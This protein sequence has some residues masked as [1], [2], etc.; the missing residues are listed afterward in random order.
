MCFLWIDFGTVHK[1]T[2]YRIEQLPE[3]VSHAGLRLAPRRASLALQP[4]VQV[5]NRSASTQH[6]V[7][8]MFMHLEGFSPPKT[9]D[10]LLRPADTTKRLQNLSA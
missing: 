8:A 6:P 5:T 9:E 7:H 4:C 10:D 3:G 2:V 1:L